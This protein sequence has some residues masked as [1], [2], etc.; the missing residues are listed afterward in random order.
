MP[1][2]QKLYPRGQVAHQSGDL[3]D[4]INIKVTTTNNAKQIHTIRQR[5]A[6][7][8]IGNEETTVTMDLLISENGIERDW[9]K[10]LKTGKIEQ[11][12]IKVP[13]ETITVNGVIKQSDLELP[14]DD[15]IKQ[16]VTF[17]GHVDD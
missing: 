7:V 1:S 6:G 11:V 16:S 10:K 8:T 3:M 2:S 13:G 15:A 4:A 5:G 12:R 17:I 14:L 9:L